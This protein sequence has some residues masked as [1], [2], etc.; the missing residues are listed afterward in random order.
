LQYIKK[1][2]ICFDDAL[3]YIDTEKN[4]SILSRYRVITNILH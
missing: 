2:N 3:L 1:V 4:I